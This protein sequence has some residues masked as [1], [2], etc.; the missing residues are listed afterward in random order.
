MLAHGSMLILNFKRC[1]PALTTK[2]LQV[3]VL[4]DLSA[5]R[6]EHMKLLLFRLNVDSVVEE[7]MPWHFHSR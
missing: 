6:M 4:L 2:R 1:C 5:I 3:T 7:S